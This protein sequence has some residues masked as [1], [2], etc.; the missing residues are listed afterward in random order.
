F[1]AFTAAELVPGVELVMASV[2]LAQLLAG[3]DVVFTGEG[4]V[5]LQSRAGKVPHPVAALAA[6][7]GVGTVIFGG[8]IDPAMDPDAEPGVIAYVP[9]V[10]EVTDLPHALAEGER[11]LER[12]A[13][14]V[15]RLL[16][17]RGPAKG[18]AGDVV[19]GSA[20]G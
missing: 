9:I 13:E 3:A 18:P 2:G 11:N 5:D 20:E 1:L 17:A 8:R 15:T 6:A 14:L 16:V 7:H 19:G 12:A 4:G 10:R